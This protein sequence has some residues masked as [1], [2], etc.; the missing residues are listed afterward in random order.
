MKKNILNSDRQFTFKDHLVW[1]KNGDE[2]L[3][4]ILPI[5]LIHEIVTLYF[6]LAYQTE[7]R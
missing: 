1:S 5:N 7:P 4:T 2:K 6:Y 3:N